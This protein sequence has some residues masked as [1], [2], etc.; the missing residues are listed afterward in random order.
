[1]AQGQGMTERQPSLAPL[2]DMS[3][4]KYKIYDTPSEWD[5][6]QEAL[7]VHLG[8]RSTSTPCYAIRSIVENPESSDFGKFIMPV[9]MDGRWKCDD[10]FSPSDLVDWREDGDIPS[11]TPGG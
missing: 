2:S 1:M 6:K 11:E 3:A 8:I 7:V 10:Q 5:E 9:C 4:K